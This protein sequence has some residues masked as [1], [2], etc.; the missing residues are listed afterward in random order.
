M[1][2]GLGNRARQGPY[3][4]GWGGGRGGEGGRGRG[5]RGGRDGRGPYRGD[6]GRQLIA[7]VSKVTELLR[8]LKGEIARRAPRAS[9]SVEG[10]EEFEE[11]DQLV[12]GS[13][14]EGED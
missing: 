3:D 4:R 10:S 13:M 14:F 12:L 11:A 6:S 9:F 2:F 1:K 8:I 7:D 5:G